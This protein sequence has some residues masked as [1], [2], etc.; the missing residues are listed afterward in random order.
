M[1]DFRLPY[2]EALAALSGFLEVL[3]RASPA[4]GEQLEW[5]ERTMDVLNLVHDIT[6]FKF[7]ASTTE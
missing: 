4:S 1:R 6:V 2:E 7:R 5:R 3:H